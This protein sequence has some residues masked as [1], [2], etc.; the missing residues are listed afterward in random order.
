MWNL[1]NKLTNTTKQRPSHGYREQTGGC[2][3][4]GGRRER[5]EGVKETQTSNHKIN[6]SQVGYVQCEEYS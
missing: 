4:G 6:D 3:R 1:K 2:Q 5:G